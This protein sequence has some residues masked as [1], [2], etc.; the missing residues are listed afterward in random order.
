VKARRISPFSAA[1]KL[2]PVG[3]LSPVNQDFLTHFREWRAE[4]G[5]NYV[6]GGVASA[7]ED[8]PPAKPSRAQLR[9]K[10]ATC[11]EQRG[12]FNHPDQHE[13]VP[14]AADAAPAPSTKRS[15]RSAKQTSPSGRYKLVSTNLKK[16]RAVDDRYKEDNRGHR[17]FNVLRGLPDSTGTLEDIVLGLVKDGGKIPGDPEKLV[18]RVMQQLQSDEYGALVQVLA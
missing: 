7:P 9:A 14:P 3:E 2:V 5:P 12:H 15:E 6:V 1:L 8:A 18:R 16:A 13:F 10:C 4:H 11:G 17:V